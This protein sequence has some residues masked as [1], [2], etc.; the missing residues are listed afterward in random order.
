MNDI[1]TMCHGA[2]NFGR[3]LFEVIMGASALATLIMAGWFVHNKV[4]ILPRPVVLAMAFAV[5]LMGLT[6][7]K[8]VGVYLKKKGSEYE[9]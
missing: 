5:T 7:L 2:M 3:M 9:H 1:K 8:V 6:A 4:H